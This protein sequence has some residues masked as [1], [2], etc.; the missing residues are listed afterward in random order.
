M[1]FVFIVLVAPMVKSLPERRETW[2]PSLDQEDPLEEEIFW[3]PT[4][5]FL[6]GKFHGQRSL[7]GC[8]LVGYEESDM[9]EL[10]STQHAYS[11]H[12]HFLES[13]YHKWMLTG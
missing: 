1:G 10:L 13:F 5:I 12:V 9:T 11:L 2:V 6:P 8:S 7:V 3:Q 4:P